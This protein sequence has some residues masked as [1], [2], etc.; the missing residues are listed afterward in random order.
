M[1]THTHFVLFNDDHPAVTQWPREPAPKDPVTE[2]CLATPY[3]HTPRNSN[4]FFF[5]FLVF[6]FSFFTDNSHSEG[7]EGQGPPITE[8]TLNNRTAVTSTVI[9]LS[10][11]PAGVPL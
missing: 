2:C 10:G 11:G 8:A 4:I 7:C 3:Q 6:S 5:S 9:S 1:Y